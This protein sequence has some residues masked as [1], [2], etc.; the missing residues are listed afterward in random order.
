MLETVKMPKL[1]A[2][3]RSGTV[4]KWLKKPGESLEQGD[5]LFTVSDGKLVKTIAAERGG[6]LESVAAGEGDSVECG[7]P[8]AV[9]RVREEDSPAVE[10]LV[11][12][13][14]PKVGSAGEGTLKK[15]FKRKGDPVTAGEM[16]F[17]MAS[18]K[19]IQNI[20]S[21]WNGVLEEILL[22][23]GTSASA[24]T[25][26]GVLRVSGQGSGK[27][28]EPLRVAV[29]GG[30]P[31]GYVAAIRAAQLG[32][33]VTLIERQWIGGTCLNVGCI[34]TKA[35]LHSAELY[36]EASHGQEAGV[37]AAGVSLD[38]EQVQRNRARISRTLSE[39]VRGLLDLNG[40]E[41]I[42]GQAA[43]A[44]PKRLRV[45]LADGSEQELCPDRVILAT[46]SIPAMPPIPGVEGNPDCIDSTGA[47]TLERL[48]KSM[49][50][51]GGGVI[52]V[53][54]ACAYA[55]FGTEVAVV[56]ML[57]R[58]LPPMD[59][60]LTELARRCMETREH[61]RFSLSTQV[62]RVEKRDGGSVVWGKLPDGAE[63]QFPAE[64]VLVAVGRR[65]SFD[66]LAPELGGVETQRGAVRVNSRM[67][68]S[69]PGVYAIGD[70]NGRQMLA[71]AA[72][73][74]GET[75]AENALGGS[76]RFD[77][78]ATPNCVYCFP[79]FAGVGLTEEQAEAA[80]KDLLIGR[81]PMAANGKSLIQESTEGMMKV[82]AE[83]ADGRILGVHIL[84]SRAT[85]LIAEAA[86]AVQAGMTIGQL[87]AVVH[88]HPTVAEA[89]REAALA[90]EGRAIHI[91]EG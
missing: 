27:K 91:Y 55:R 23:A 36:Y 70:C 5:G 25:V 41:V 53:E 60:E 86:L 17:S 81:F 90:A 46:G 63:V 11:E 71:H 44:G 59:G 4:K 12:L 66:G 67:E 38:W 56:E 51:I 2:D 14:M 89:L 18:G 84:G 52:G 24:G 16:L 88:A 40:V 10:T 6:V 30:G 76:A 13:R 42:R 79:E 29:V 64:K 61:I 74:M 72:S 49:V 19:L 57:P 32:G 8:V 75:A 82:I 34:P 73:A 20:T 85:D 58:L 35:L 69:A 78:R 43:F 54:L 7:A 33:K 1:K 9:I 26:V 48:P 47:L 50:L 68:T 39:G 77:G 15:W 45:A 62:V 28:E 80:G 21:E 37:C 31:G 87:S 3:M 83:K 22:P 65:P